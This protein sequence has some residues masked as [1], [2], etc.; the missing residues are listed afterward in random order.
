MIRYSLGDFRITLELTAP[1]LGQLARHKQS[2]SDAPEAGGQLF[3][4]IN[5]EANTW[6]VIRATGP[7]K[8]DVRSRFA[9]RPCRRREQ[10]EIFQAFSEGLHYIGDWH[11]H[12]EA[13]P[14]PSAFDLHS[15][16]ELVCES[17]HELPGFVMVIVGQAD[18]PE[19]LWA[20]FHAGDS[21]YFPLSGPRRI[22][23]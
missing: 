7:R 13:S 14:R 19:G 16:S 2:D 15:M 22:R 21:R 12:P 8:E 5:A 1:V 10:L 23:C 3:A 6:R 9:F 4:T 18:F 11:T 17:E 20:S